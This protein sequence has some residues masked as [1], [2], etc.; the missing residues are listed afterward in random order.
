MHITVTACYECLKMVTFMYITQNASF[1]NQPLTGVQFWTKLQILLCLHLLE[2][3][4]PFQQESNGDSFRLCRPCRPGLPPICLWEE[5][6]EETWLAK[7]E[8]QRHFHALF[9]PIARKCTYR[10]YIHDKCHAR[11]LI[12]LTKFSTKPGLKHSSITC[13]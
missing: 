7:E 12:L 5:V 3:L 4:R 6:T 13:Y 11:V 8:H 10:Q 1:I 2:N 9:H